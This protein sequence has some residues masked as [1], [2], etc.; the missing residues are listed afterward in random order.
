MKKI[1]YLMGIDWYWIK[2]RPQ[3]LAE[4]LAKDYNVT[5]VYM[6]EVFCRQELRK[7][8]DELE[9]SYAVPAIPY[10][11]KNSLVHIIQKAM[12]HKIMKRANEFDIIW[13]GQ[14]LLYNYIPSTYK[15][16]IIYD[17]MDNHEALCNDSK[18]KK[19]IQ[20]TE[21][22]LVK[23]ADIIFVSSMGLRRRIESIGEANKVTL[24]R[25]GVYFNEIHLPEHTQSNEIYKIGYFGTLAEWFDFP[26][27]L[28]SLKKYQNIEYHLWG[29]ISNIAIP[30]HDRV[31]WEGVIEH[32]KLW[33]E[34][35][36][37]DCLIMPF[38]INAII[39]DVDPV[40]LYEYISMGKS[41]ISVFYDEVKRFEDFIYFYRTEEEYWEILNKLKVNSKPKYSSE[42]QKN[43]L[44]DNTWEKRYNT[45][46][47]NIQLLDK[48][49]F[50]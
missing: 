38:T 8:K 19:V 47:E 13:V 27:L 35:K 29:P 7:D 43:F 44:A 1:L 24:I 25:N 26:L 3:I 20:R 33:D 18:I 15:G 22:E 50:D 39:A 42:K 31:I 9:Q 37:M 4:Y 2:Q 46:K 45:V 48:G 49:A 32:R 40:K 6:K 14:P 5:V 21:N 10:R 16:K 11:D 12:F 34:V 36:S 28:N 17:C 30:K 23:R 41:V